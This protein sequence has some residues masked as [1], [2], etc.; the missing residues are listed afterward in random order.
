[1]GLVVYSRTQVAFQVL[2]KSILKTE[3]SDRNVIL[4][5]GHSESQA[6]RVTWDYFYGH[7]MQN[8][9]NIVG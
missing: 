9:I 4:F 1:M 3:L 6:S 5:Q 2:Q 8:F 7:Q